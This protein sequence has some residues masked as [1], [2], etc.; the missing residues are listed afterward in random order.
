MRNWLLRAV[1]RRPGLHRRRHR[2]PRH[3]GPRPRLGA[4]HLPEVR[5]A[6]RS[7]TRSRACRR[8]ARSIPEMDLRPR[9]HRR[10]V[11]RRLHGGP[12]GAAS[13]RTCSRPPSPA[14]RSPT[15]RT[16]TRTTPSATSA[17]RRE[18]RRGLRRGVAADATPTD[19]KRPLL[20]VHGTADDNVYFRHTLQA[21]RRAVPRRQGLRGAAA[22]GPD[23]HG[24]RPG[25]DG[26]A[27]DAGRGPLCEAP[28]I[29][30]AATRRRFGIFGLM[31]TSRG[32]SQNPKAATSR[33][34]PK[35]LAAHALSR[36]MAR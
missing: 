23:A 20:L 8:S 32:S 34:T 24:A 29:W 14:P 33:R 11:V 26:A 36:R 25:R 31:A 3:A 13:G 9:R 27:L 30:S 18:R 35:G 5:H 2:Q 21:G 16:T 10:L 22:A 4:G 1:A 12:G 19:L 6:C 15:G 7:R 17:C 28:V